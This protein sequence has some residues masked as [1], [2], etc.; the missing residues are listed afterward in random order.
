MSPGGSGGHSS[1][2]S[3]LANSTTEIN[4][5]IGKLGAAAAAAAAARDAGGGSSGVGTLDSCGSSVNS[6][7]GPGTNHININNH[8]NNAGGRSAEQIRNITSDYNTLLKRATEEI[9]SL[10]KDKYDLEVRQTR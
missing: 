2:Y 10:A 1:A 6:S 9:K 3:S 5:D 8:N 4:E 7:S